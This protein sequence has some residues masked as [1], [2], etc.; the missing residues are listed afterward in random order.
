MKRDLSF[1]EKIKSL[2]VAAIVMIVGLA[3]FKFVPMSLFGRDILFDASMHLTTAIFVLY[4]FWY[5]IDQNKSWRLPY[6]I[7]SIAVI[8]VVSVQR[9]IANAHNDTGL[10]A[11]LIISFIAIVVS[12]WEYFKNKFDF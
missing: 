9:I 6:F 1:G 11:G 2:A 8:I 3:L 5:F 7:F 10:L 4:F 12:R